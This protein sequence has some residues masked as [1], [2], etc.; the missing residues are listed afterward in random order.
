MTLSIITRV[1]GFVPPLDALA[2]P[3]L[4]VAVR[5]DPLNDL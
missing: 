5:Q 1:N 2:L 3:R 4:P